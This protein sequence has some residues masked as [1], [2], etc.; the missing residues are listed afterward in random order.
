MFDDAVGAF[1]VHLVEHVDG[2]V[3]RQF[4]QNLRDFGAGHAV[5]NVRADGLFEHVDGDGDST[6]WKEKQK[7]GSI[8]FID[9][10]ETV[11]HV[12]G[13]KLGEECA[14]LVVVTVRQ[15]LTELDDQV[16]QI[17]LTARN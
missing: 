13:V 15:Q 14:Q 3:G 10:F 8:L 4:L 1:V 12:G 17:F 16:R 9:G 11:R 6:G 7:A 5:E 2:V